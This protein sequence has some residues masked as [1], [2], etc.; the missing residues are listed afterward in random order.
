M[1]QLATVQNSITVH[2]QHNLADQLYEEILKSSSLGERQREVGGV[3][4]GTIQPDRNGVQLTVRLF[5]PIL[6]GYQSGPLYHLSEEDRSASRNFITRCV[7]PQWP[8]IGIYRSHCRPGVELDQEDLGLAREF[9]TNPLGII[10][11]VKPLETDGPLGSLFVLTGPELRTESALPLPFHASFA[12]PKLEQP[13]VPTPSPPPIEDS[14][15]I[16]KALADP[17]LQP[18]APAKPA[19]EPKAEEQ[20]AEE[21]KAEEQKAEEPKASEP[22]VI[23]SVSRKRRLTLLGGLAAIV[24]AGFIS[25]WTWQRNHPAPQPKVPAAAVAVSELGLKAYVE[26]NHFRITWNPDAPRVASAA[27]GKLIVKDGQ[28]NTDIPLNSIELRGGSVVYGPITDHA[29]FELRVGSATES[30]SLSGV[31]AHTG[32]E[33]S[34]NGEPAKPEKEKVNAPDNEDL[35]AIPKAGVAASQPIHNELFKP[36]RP[37]PV[38]VDATFGEAPVKPEVPRRARAG[39]PP[40]EPLPPPDLS[41]F[42]ESPVAGMIQLPPIHSPPLLTGPVQPPLLGPNEQI[43]Y[44]AARPV[45]H[46][47][48][49]V[50]ANALRLVVSRITIRVKV[51]IDTQGRVVRAESLS[52]G[53]ALI[54]YLSNLSVNAAREWLFLPARRGDRNVESEMVLEFGFNSNGSTEGSPE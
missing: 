14:E 50:S 26:A 48:P 8:L 11:L 49:K 44:I 51:S 28:F 43:D 31:E 20:K 9:L 47:A 13:V 42:V 2:W 53:N 23:S 54:D 46:V 6:C 12:D 4:L 36:D 40:G 22:R 34:R 33:P 32:A 19:E 52:R 10:L 21:Q 1:V 16:A 25:L 17:A 27:A 5:V 37:I 39:T 18:D 15:W 29:T 24:A 30:V 35:R 7:S 45:K 41:P 38:P 3:L